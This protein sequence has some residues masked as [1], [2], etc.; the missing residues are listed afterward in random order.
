MLLKN[1]K[2]KSNRTTLEKLNMHMNI[3]EQLREQEQIFL[4]SRLQNLNSAFQGWEILNMM[5]KMF[6]WENSG[7]RA[8]LLTWGR[9]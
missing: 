2:P 9:K 3:W 6:H 8:D 5:K 4:K 7:Q 1:K